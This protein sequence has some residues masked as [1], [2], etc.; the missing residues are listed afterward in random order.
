LI[1]TWGGGN[2]PGTVAL[3]WESWHCPKKRIK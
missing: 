2:G 1:W 3:T